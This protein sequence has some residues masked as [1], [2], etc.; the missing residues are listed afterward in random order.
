MGREGTLKIRWVKFEMLRLTKSTARQSPFGVAFSDRDILENLGN[1]II[2]T[3][4]R[5]RYVRNLVG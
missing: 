4:A 3:G 2:G 5:V 1:P